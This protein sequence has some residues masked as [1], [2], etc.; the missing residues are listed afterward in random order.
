M[1]AHILRQHLDAFARVEINDLNAVLAKPIHSTA[2][3]HGLSDKYRSESKL[4]D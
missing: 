4:A 1:I 2:K 3:I